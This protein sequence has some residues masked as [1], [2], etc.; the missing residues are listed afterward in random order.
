MRQPPGF[1][2]GT[3]QVCKLI[4][5]IYG[6]KQA[7]RIWQEL[8]KECLLR[9]GFKVSDLDPALYLMRVDGTLVVLL[10]FVDDTIIGSLDDSLMDRVISSLCAEFKITD[11]GRPQR[12]V[13]M[14]FVRDEE[15]GEMWVHQ[16]PYL[17][18]LAE[19][20]GVSTG[21]LP[22]TPLP[23]NFVLQHAWEEGASDA[24]SPIPDLDA[25][26]EGADFKRYQ[27]IVGA[28]NYVAH[29]T[30]LDIALLSTRCLAAFTLLS[31]GTWLQ[32]SIA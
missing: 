15:S 23:Y 20:L 30:R 28:L 2:D 16:G 25:A 18:E 13:G 7:P 4:R 6:L 11:L 31:A 24:P 17:L 14:Y 3:S 26:L 8:L 29:S 22:D 5:S 32:Q 27:R 12:Y 9:I 19:K 10:D 21:D 1:E